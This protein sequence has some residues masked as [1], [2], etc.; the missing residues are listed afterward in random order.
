[1]SE[2]ILKAL[3]HLFAIIASPESNEEERKQ[4]VGEFLKQQLNTEQVEEYLKVF[5]NYYRIYQAKQ[6]RKGKKNKS[7]SVSSVKVLKICNEINKELTR[8]QKVIVLYNLFE[9]IKSDFEEV[10]E[11]ELEFIKTVSDEFFIPEDEYKRIK[12]L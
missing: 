6:S 10:T 11:Q 2:R 4:V 8:K 12:D 5:E 9:F 3:M 7:I 1:M